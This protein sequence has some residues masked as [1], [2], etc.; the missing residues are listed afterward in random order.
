MKLQKNIER[1]AI[2]KYN[3]SQIRKIH[4]DL[5]KVK[6]DPAEWWTTA[7]MPTTAATPMRQ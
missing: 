3:F 2:T 1:T 6:G 5:S 4:S 7:P